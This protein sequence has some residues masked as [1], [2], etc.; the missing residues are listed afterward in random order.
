[1]GTACSAVFIAQ[2]TWPFM[3]LNIFRQQQQQQLAMVIAATATPLTPIA[4]N[5]ILTAAT[6]VI[7]FAATAVTAATSAQ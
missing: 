1:M 3:K 4:T 6:T 2:G 5:M 7:L